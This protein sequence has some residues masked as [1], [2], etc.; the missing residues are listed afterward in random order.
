MELVA[1]I[2]LSKNIS[3]AIYVT[4]QDSNLFYMQE[5]S[6]ALVGVIS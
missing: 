6:D 1:V 3:I 4:G 2:C 5:L